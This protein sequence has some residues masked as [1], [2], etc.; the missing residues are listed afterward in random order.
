VLEKIE[1]VAQGVV[2]Q[3]FGT[4][5]FTFLESLED[6]PREPSAPVPYIW[7]EIGFQGPLTG[8]L[9]LFLPLQR[10]QKMASQFMGLEDEEIPESQAI[11]MVK[12]LCN[13]VCGNLSSQLDRKAIWR[14]SLPSARRVC[15]QEM[16]NDKEVHGLT[17][18]FFAEGDPVELR[19][20]WRQEPCQ[21]EP[22]KP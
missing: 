4:M 1:R 11:D 6:R 3:V 18:R 19:L 15:F 22:E 2:A 14:L 7:G 8:R 21:E 9:A 10:A 20:D 16:K 17:L 12:E 13:V 5:F